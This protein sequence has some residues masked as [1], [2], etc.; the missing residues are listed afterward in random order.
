MRF[1]VYGAGWR[2][3]CK[4]SKECKAKISRPFVEFARFEPEFSWLGNCHA[5]VLII[6]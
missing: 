6:T 1:Q 5:P 2:E 3:G 4:K